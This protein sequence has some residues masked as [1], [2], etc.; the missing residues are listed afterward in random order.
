MPRTTGAAY[1][2]TP[3]SPT[4]IEV[5]GDLTGWDVGLGGVSKA[6]ALLT[7]L[8]LTLLLTAC[9]PAD[10]T[11]GEGQE[12]APSEAVAPAETVPAQQ[13]GAEPDPG[14]PTTEAIGTREEPAPAQDAGVSI[15]L[16][17]LPVG[18][19]TEVAGDDP[20]LRCV[21]VNWTGQVDL[22]GGI[23]LELTA[24]D[25][26]PTGVYQVSDYGCPG[27][28]PGCLRAPGVLEDPGQCD[29]AVRQ[30][31]P[32]ADGTGSLGVAAGR[33]SCKAQESGLCAGLASRLAVAGEPARVG[34]DDAVVAQPEPGTG[35]NPGDSD[36]S[37]DT[38][39]G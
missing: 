30:V 29:I 19:F 38:Q 3:P 39:D 5:A 31:V 32:S 13:P 2:R 8:L 1:A 7:L 28:V 12:P 34:W 22:P 14:T 24:F 4:P 26:Q 35:T 27:D 33:V 11:G 6:A 10:P 36:S 9:G 17:G 15:E 20:Y 23:N 25:L 21:R 18:G 16:A 37:T